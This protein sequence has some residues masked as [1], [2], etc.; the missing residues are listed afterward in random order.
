MKCGKSMSA[1]SSNYNFKCDYAKVSFDGFINENYFQINSKEKNLL[2]NIE[3]SHGI[4]KNPINNKLE[5]FIGLLLKSKYDGIG[6]RRPIDLSIAL[7]ISGSM[8][9][10]DDSI[11]KKSRINIAKDALKKLISIIDEKNDRISLVTF[12]DNLQKIFPLL[13]KNE[14]QNNIYMKNIDSI[15]ANGGTNLKCA[16]NGAMENY[17]DNNIINENREKR[18]I[19]IT[20]AIYNDNS[21]YNLIKKC[22]EIN[23]ISLTIMTISSEAN[24][25]LTDKLCDFKG[26]NY[27]N[28]TKTSELETY[29]VKQFK[30]IFF[31]I[32]HYLKLNITSKNSK[33]SKCI[34]GGENSQLP[35]K[36]ENLPAPNF[37]LENSAAPLA[38][39]IFS[40]E[41]SFNLG[42]NFP[43]DLI[44]IEEN[45]EIKYYIE[46]NLIL[47]K[48]DKKS[49]N[50]ENFNI[51]L[52]YE[53]I[54]GEKYNN[55]YFYEI[56]ENEQNKVF[57]KNENIQKGIYIYY[58]T[59]VLNT[60]TNRINNN[61]NNEEL[62]N[63]KEK[64]MNFFQ[65]NFVMKPDISKTRKNLITYIKL[66]EDRYT[67]INKKLKMK[68]M[69]DFRSH[70]YRRRPQ[71]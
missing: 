1:N 21:L 35:N 46:G 28:I 30:Y 16:I 39:E 57:Y 15:K 54:N 13:N 43:S 37:I 69:T 70:Y 44:S 64:I 11:L 50:L 56:K 10:I 61:K 66:L 2:L 62:L 32:A 48:V 22:V 27:F 20:D 5:T 68:N 18:I 65:E 14:I 12:N 31:P 8:S 58:Y 26:C 53:N 17:N 52:E 51:N 25:N 19:L 29:L 33:I 45:K 23:N 7:D 63:K 3:I 71:W 59:F 60:I 9:S 49:K 41:I 47:I 40:E 34:G 55:N 38:N 6:D 24:L 67:E 42:S 36:Y 4:S